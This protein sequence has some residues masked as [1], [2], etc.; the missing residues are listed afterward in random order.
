MSRLY[1]FSNVLLELGGLNELG[2]ELSKIAVKRP[3][4]ISDPGLSA[5]GLV[6]RC[7]DLV[8]ELSIYDQT[9]AN[10][11]EAA[12]M[13]AAKLYVANECDGIVA[14]GGGSSMDLG[15]AVALL[16]SHEGKLAEFDVTK[17]NPRPL[18]Q[19]PP[20][21]VIPTTSGTGTE[22]S[23]GSV[24]TLNNGHKAIIDSDRLI[25]IAVICD[26]ELTLSLPAKLTA[27]TGIDALSHCIEGYCSNISNP[28]AEPVALDG[29]RR[30]AIALP[31]AMVEPQDIGARTDMMIGSLQGGL[32][33]SMELGAAHA[34]SVPLGAHFHVHHGEL[35]GAVLG[36]AM[37]FNE[38]V[39]PD[40]MSSVRN[41]LGVPPDAS[42]REWMNEFCHRL[43]LT[44]EISKLGAKEEALSTIAKE[45]AES[46]FNHTNP[47]LGTAD[48]YLSLLKLQ[49]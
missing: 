16:V 3:L 5:L 44:T 32:A 46:P 31:R 8:P 35:T 18:D 6:A 39:Q 28:L 40:K 26:P 48:E 17:P 41:A 43:G 10:P 2:S 4:L 22:V 12:A 42:I 7:Q 25:P 45:A 14:L 9:P 34:L 15:K 49:F 1:L 13:E 20:L 29:I 19:V 47:K 21:L 27:A 24:I 38:P 33:M 30:I 23:I 11:T 37:Q 36:A